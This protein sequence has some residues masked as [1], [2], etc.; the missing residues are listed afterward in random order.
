MMI[1]ETNVEIDN[2]IEDEE[3]ENEQEEVDLS[4]AYIPHAIQSYFNSISQYPLLTKEEE[5]ELGQAILDGVEGAREKLIQS[6]LR[7]VISIAKGY[8]HKSKIPFID[9]IQEGNM[10]LIIAADKFDYTKGYKFS[11]YATHWIKQKILKAMAEQSRTIRM[12]ANIVGELSKINSATYKLSVELMRQPTLE[13]IAQA[14]ETTV[15][16]I[17]Y[18][19]SVSQDSFSLDATLDGGDEENVTTY[20]DMVMD[21]DVADPVENV[22]N[23]ERSMKI[24]QVLDTLDE[25]E[26]EVILMRFGFNGRALTLDEIGEIFDLTKERIRQIEAKALRKLRNPIRANMLKDC[27]D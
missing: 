10:G 4:G 14:A 25:R 26:K 16:R 5:E 8:Y 27:L 12:P 22:F 1:D 20:G 13:E 15:E 24:Q 6:N 21:H 11:T 19:F 2:L 7:L 17:E 18:I 3:E 23:E 9:L